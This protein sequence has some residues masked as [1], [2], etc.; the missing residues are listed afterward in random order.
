MSVVALAFDNLEYTDS[1]QKDRP[2]AKHITDVDHPQVA[3]QERHADR[4]ENET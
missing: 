4:D 3:E 2:E 1:D